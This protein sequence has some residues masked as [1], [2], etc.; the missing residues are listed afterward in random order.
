MLYI[1]TEDGEEQG[2]ISFVVIFG[3]HGYS[4]AAVS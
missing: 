1:E 4:Y 3:R 2:R